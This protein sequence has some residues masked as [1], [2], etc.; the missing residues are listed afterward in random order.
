MGR[1]E[2]VCALAPHEWL[3][4]WNSMAPLLCLLWPLPSIPA[5]SRS[6][7]HVAE[8]AHV[9]LHAGSFTVGWVIVWAI[10]AGPVELHVLPD[11]RK[12]QDP[13]LLLQAKLF[14]SQTLKH[15]KTMFF[16][17]RKAVFALQHRVYRRGL[18]RSSAGASMFCPLSR[19]KC[20]F[21][22]C[23]ARSAGP[24][25]WSRELSVILFERLGTK[26]VLYSNSETWPLQKAEVSSSSVSSA[27]RVH[28]ES[29]VPDRCPHWHMPSQSTSLALI[30]AKALLRLSFL[31]AAWA[32]NGES[33]KLKTKRLGQGQSC[34]YAY[35]QIPHSFQDRQ[36]ILL[37]ESVLTCPN[38]GKRRGRI[39]SDLER[40]TE[41]QGPLPPV[42]LIV[43]SRRL[44]R[45]RGGW[46]SCDWKAGIA[47]QITK[48]SGVKSCFSKSSLQGL[49]K[50]R[51]RSGEGVGGEGDSFRGMGRQG[52]MGSGPMWFFLLEAS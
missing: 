18:K 32:A 51:K 30:F 16:D 49:E 45:I 19:N 31:A 47:R 52:G 50:Q 34:L 48:A 43:M 21:P 42:R 8:L 41:M 33:E 29:L 7:V 15:C 36:W 40:S 9:D 35:A 23:Q 10:I 44:K 26:S 2:K 4:V 14:W 27:A 3:L 20:R 22:W 13:L 28:A 24:R 6:A 11:V 38:A 37:N 5:L 17:I 39:T 12:V 1:S 46:C 25:W